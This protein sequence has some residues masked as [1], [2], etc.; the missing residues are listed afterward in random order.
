MALEPWIGLPRDEHLPGLHQTGRK[1][2]A[3]SPRRHRARRIWASNVKKMA[4]GAFQFLRAT[5]WRWARSIYRVCPDLKERADVLAVGDVHV[6]NFGTWRD[7]EGRLVW[8][9]NDFDEAARM[10]Y[11]ARYGAASGKRDA[12]GGAGYHEDRD[13]R[14]HRGG[15]RGGFAGT[16]AVRARRSPQDGCVRSSS[17][18]KKSARSSGPSSIP[19]RSREEK[20]RQGRCGHER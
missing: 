1:L 20:P 7:A 16:R 5:Y 13:L 15:L 3:A 6:E 12:G 8:G 19:R 17:S 9:M 14:Q 10:P 4:D 18:A 2:V 11:T